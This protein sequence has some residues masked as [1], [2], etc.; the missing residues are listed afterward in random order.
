MI[1]EPLTRLAA[2]L[3]ATVQTRIALAATEVEEESLRYFSC[4][5]LS[6]AAMFC[7]GMAVVLGTLLAVVLYGETHRIGI[8]LTLI[9]L[10]GLASAVLALR[11]R[12]QYQTKPPLLAHSM[13]E[14]AR[15]ADMLQPRA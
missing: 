3:L 11:V 1:V 2:T 9:V 6:M 10:F 13:N 14:L 15:D 8:L 7:L 5:M 12:R 4:L